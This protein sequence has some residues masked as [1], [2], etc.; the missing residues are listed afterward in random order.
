MNNRLL[1]KLEK[2]GIIDVYKQ[3]DKHASRLVARSMSFFN[4]T[5]TTY[6]RNYLI[7]GEYSHK[8]IAR[9]KTPTLFMRSI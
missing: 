5:L 9:Y 2:C 7:L 1:D 4:R 3:G 8:V 6:Y